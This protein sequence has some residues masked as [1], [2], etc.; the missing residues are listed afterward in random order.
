MI[1]CAAVQRIDFFLF[2][3]D[4]VKLFCLF[5]F[6]HYMVN[7]DDHSE[8][9]VRSNA[10][11]IWRF[12]VHGGRWHDSSWLRGAHRLVRIW[13][14]RTPVLHQHHQGRPPTCGVIGAPTFL[15]SVC[16]CVSVCLSVR[17]KTA[18]KPTDH[19]TGMN[20]LQL[21]L[22]VVKFSRRL[23]S[24]LTSGAIFV[25]LIFMIRKLPIGLTIEN[26]SSYFDTI[27]TVCT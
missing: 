5:C 17:E 18:E 1:F 13:V 12:S 25:F 19:V 11:T 4:L 22:E 15:L 8:I 10:M 14:R 20:M 9:E 2:F 21:T 26:C 6:Y 27:Y 3:Y 23:T 16:L 7:K 24:S